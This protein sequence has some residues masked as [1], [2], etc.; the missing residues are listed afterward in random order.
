[1]GPWLTHRSN[2]HTQMACI[3][4]LRPMGHHWLNRMDHFQSVSSPALSCVLSSWLHKRT[5]RIRIDCLFGVNYSQGNLIMEICNRFCLPFGNTINF[6]IK[7][8]RLNAAQYAE[9]CCPIREWQNWMVFFQKRFS[10]TIWH[11]PGWAFVD[12]PHG[13]VWLQPYAWL[14]LFLFS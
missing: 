11:Q 6:R 2:E 14:A 1:M 4:D 9:K 5:K 3:R 12:H 8:F 10:E 13:Y 7:F